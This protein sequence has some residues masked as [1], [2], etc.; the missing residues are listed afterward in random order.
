MPG[1]AYPLASSG[2]R[3]EGGMAEKVNVAVIAP[4]SRD[5]LLNVNDYCG[6]TR[7]PIVGH[8]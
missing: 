2:G 1:R 7:K 6:G 4:G 8:G 5:G 3:L